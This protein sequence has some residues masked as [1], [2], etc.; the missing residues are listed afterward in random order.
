MKQ[1]RMISFIEA[2]IG[3][4]I[5]FAVSIALS[6]FVYPLFGHAFTL[7]QNFWITAIFTVASVARTYAVR[8][9]ADKHL[10]TFVAWAMWGR[11]REITKAIDGGRVSEYAVVSTR[12]AEVVGYWAYGSWDPNQPYQGGRPAL[13]TK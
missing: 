3:T 8:R 2:G 9:W 4:A 11:L 13:W 12:T 5:G 1:S 10:Q 7:A 6:I